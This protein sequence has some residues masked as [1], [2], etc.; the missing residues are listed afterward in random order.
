MSR[1]GRQSSRDA[2][3]RPVRI[4]RTEHEVIGRMTIR[5][6]TYLLLEELGDADRTRYKALDPDARGQLRSIHVLPRSAA[7][8]GCILCAERF[9]ESR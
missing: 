2:D 9:L 1:S 5:R 6:H 8:E 3:H 4:G 7:A